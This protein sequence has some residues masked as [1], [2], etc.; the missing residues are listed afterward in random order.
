MKEIL[1][2]IKVKKRTEIQKQNCFPNPNAHFK[3][4]KK[5]KT[6]ELWEINN[7][8]IFYIYWNT[9]ITRY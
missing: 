5:H 8:K 2:Y 7:E 9:Y 1:F 4:Q 6:G 3:K